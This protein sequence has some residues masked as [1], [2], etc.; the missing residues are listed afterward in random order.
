M[1]HVGFSVRKLHFSTAFSASE[2][3]ACRFQDSLPNSSQ[4]LGSAVQFND[5]TNIL[6]SVSMAGFLDPIASGQWLV[7]DALE[8]LIIARTLALLD[9]LHVL[10]G[11]LAGLK[12]IQF[13]DRQRNLA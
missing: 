12:T 3:H 4:R 13:F 5:P 11:E 1:C 8:P 7:A 2:S 9:D 10:V 6:Q